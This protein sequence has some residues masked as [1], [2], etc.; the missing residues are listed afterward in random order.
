MADPPKLYTDPKYPLAPRGEWYGDANYQT[1]GG[2]L[3]EMTPAEYLA[4]V[5]PLKI[6]DI[7]RENIDDLKSHIESG[8]T[9]DPL[10]ISK[11]GKEDGR[12][13]AVAAKELGI[14]K[15]PVLT[16]DVKS[17]PR[18]D[19]N[20]IRQT[21]DLIS[22]RRFGEMLP[23]PR[24]TEPPEGGWKPPKNLGQIVRGIGNLAVRKRLFPFIQAAQMAWGTLSDE[25]K[26]GVEGF[27]A[28]D[29]HE[30]LGMEKSGLEYFKDFLGISEEDLPPSNLPTDN[31]PLTN[32]Q[33]GELLNLYATQTLKSKPRNAVNDL[34]QNGYWPEELRSDG[35]EF[36]KGKEQ[37]ARQRQ[38]E[39]YQKSDPLTYRNPGHAIREFEAGKS[40]QLEEEARRSKLA[41]LR[42]RG[43]ALQ[44]LDEEGL[45]NKKAVDEIASWM[46][47]IE[48]GGIGYVTEAL[49]RANME[50]VPRALKKE[51]WTVRHASMGSDKKMSSRY[52]VSPDGRFEVRLSD[53]Y[54]PDTPQR[55]YMRSQTGGPRWNE[56]IVVL[57]TES[58]RSIIDEIKDLY[59]DSVGD[60]EGY[61]SGGFVVKPLYDRT[62]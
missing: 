23:A 22:E 43:E 17:E 47:L 38:Q 25:Q 10:Q 54:L 61:A 48:H 35:I 51:G 5:R 13:R 31:L 18:S 53:H 14:Q 6:D 58:P 44:G 2:T 30:L 60:K 9:L 3:V 55:E 36:L 37:R 52:I 8:R 26:S 32:S 16:W 40:L 33:R 29:V 56:D 11:A 41:A 15:I 24:P 4:R 20:A 42:E 57:G 21:R 12:H 28:K 7:S 19:P 34:I 45:W 49:A 50:S 27:F 59:T 46:D 1:T 62:P 39:N